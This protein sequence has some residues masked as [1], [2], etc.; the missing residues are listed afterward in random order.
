M[1]VFFIWPRPT[2]RRRAVDV[3][4]QLRVV[5]KTQAAAVVRMQ[6]R[7]DRLSQDRRILRTTV[8]EL[9]YRSDVDEIERRA[10]EIT[11]R[12]QTRKVDELSSLLCKERTEV[13]RLRQLLSTTP[14]ATE[15]EADT[16]VINPP[17][18]IGFLTRT[19]LDSAKSDANW[20]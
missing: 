9:V 18:S 11:Y 7:I 16:V 4:G 2:G 3:V 14:L 5:V 10:T 19:G 12:E 13:A 6:M 8:Q 1:Y 20:W 15:A 17:G